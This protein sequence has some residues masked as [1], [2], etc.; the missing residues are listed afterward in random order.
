MAEA[1][2]EN[3]EVGEK[4]TSDI[5]NGPGQLFSYYLSMEE[6]L[7][8]LKIL[9][10]DKE[11]VKELKQKPLSRHYFAISTNPGEQFYL[12]ATLAAWLVRKS[13]KPFESPQEYDDPNATISTILDFTRSCGGTV[14]F[15]PNRLKQGYGEHAVYVLNCLADYSLKIKV[16]ARWPK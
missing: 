11:F 14:D 8:K 2:I 5:I 1:S 10:Y 15:P 12:F 6:L 9:N 7:E 13:G 3:F 16:P 4:N